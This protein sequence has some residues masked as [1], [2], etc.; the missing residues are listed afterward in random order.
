M[1]LKNLN[2]IIIGVVND[3]YNEVLPL[4]LVI[5]EIIKKKPVEALKMV[6]LKEGIL[7]TKLKD[8][9]ISNQN[10]V[11]LASKLQEKVIVLKNFSLG[12][13]KK[14]I[15]FFKTLFKKIVSYGRKII[16]IDKNSYMFENLVDN[17]YVINK[18]SIIY[19]TSDLYDP[20]LS[21]YI[22]VPKI[23]EFVNVSASKGININHYLELDELLKAIYRIKQ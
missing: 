2:G 7:D 21:K 6:G 13:T 11:I 5:R 23:V 22:D 3:E 4:D 1:E 17:L 18:D 8:L 19:T 16:L 15:D 10:K 20:V 9:S 12:L 14:D